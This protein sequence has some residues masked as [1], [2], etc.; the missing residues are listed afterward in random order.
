MSGQIKLNDN[1]S[2]LNIEDLQ[3]LF[4][5]KGVEFAQK[6]LQVQTRSETIFLELS[7]GSLQEELYSE[8]ETYKKSPDQID[9][10]LDQTPK[11]N[12]IRKH[13]FNTTK[14]VKRQLDSVSQVLMKYETEC[15]KEWDN[16]YPVWADL[17]MYKYLVKG[18]F[19]TRVGKEI[20]SP[21]WKSIS[22]LKENYLQLTLDLARI[23]FEWIFDWQ[24]KDL[25]FYL[26]YVA[27]AKEEETKKYAH[28]ERSLKLG[29]FADGIGAATGE[30]I[31]AAFKG[32]LG[33]RAEIA[34]I[35]G[36]Y[37]VG[38]FFRKGMELKVFHELQMEGSE[39]KL[40]LTNKPKY[41]SFIEKIKDEQ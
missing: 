25:Q 3:T 13:I 11:I 36:P 41:K 16:L 12:K 34:E 27:N 30:A 17:N 21:K 24:G 2:P 18:K 28:L 31:G 32:L 8:Y 40:E 7:L 4:I 19:K 39:Y 37:F 20:E 14:F 38:L 35:V 9:L 5:P 33:D 15:D 1:V 23:Y 29:D 22:D 10:Y 6:N 26:P